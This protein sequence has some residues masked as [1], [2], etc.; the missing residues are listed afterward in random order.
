MATTLVAQ[1]RLDFS[2]FEYPNIEVGLS[3]HTASTFALLHILSSDPQPAVHA[4]RTQ[5]GA[6]LA[7]GPAAV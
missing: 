4:F 6:E 1:V 2:Y 7:S 5:P 3:P